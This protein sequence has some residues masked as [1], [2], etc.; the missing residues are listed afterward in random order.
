MAVERKVEPMKQVP[1]YHR[2]LVRSG[3]T[4]TL[5]VGRILPTD[6][7]IVKLRVVKMEGRTCLL[8]IIKL[9]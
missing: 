2:K 5:S 4:R 7:L 9:D 8:E 1:F 3:S 6:W